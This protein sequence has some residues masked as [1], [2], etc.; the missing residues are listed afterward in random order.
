MAAGQYHACSC[1]YFGFGGTDTKQFYLPSEI[2]LGRL[3]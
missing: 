3:I 1:V 2:I